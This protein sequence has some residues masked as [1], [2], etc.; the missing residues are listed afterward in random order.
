MKYQDELEVGKRTRKPEMTVKQ[1]LDYYR[2]K[3]L[4]KVRTREKS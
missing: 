3:L 4:S 2:N 1:Q